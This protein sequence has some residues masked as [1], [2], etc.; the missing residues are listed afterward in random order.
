MLYDFELAK[1]IT[2]IEDD[3]LLGFYVNSIILKIERI[4]GYKLS[5]ETY[6]HFISGIDKMYVYTI[7]RPLKEI[8]HISKN[9]FDIT[10]HCNIESDRKIGL[11]FE[12][13]NSE[14]IRAKYIA[15]Y[16][17]LP[18]NIQL[19]IFLQVKN[20]TDEIKNSNIKSYSI[21]TISYTFKDT[22]DKNSDFIKEVKNIFG[23]I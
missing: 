15:G 3:E 6:E 16:E 8:L 5:I 13:C 21:E 20:I 7:G 14:K 11:D 2:K 18:E 17:E 1:K 12:L 10:E 23:G 4:I 19:F 9:N 22:E